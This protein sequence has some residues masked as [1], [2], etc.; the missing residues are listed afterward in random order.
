MFKKKCKSA[1]AVEG[2]VESLMLDDVC[3]AMIEINFQHIS[4]EVSQNYAI[5]QLTW[6]LYPGTKKKYV[7]LVKS[8]WFRNKVFIDSFFD[9]SRFSL[10]ARVVVNSDSLFQFCLDDFNFKNEWVNAFYNAFT[11]LGLGCCLA[12][13]NKHIKE[14]SRKVISPHVHIQARCT[15]DSCGVKF[16]FHCF[17]KPEPKRTVCQFGTIDQIKKNLGDL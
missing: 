8:F 5:N 6:K 13:K 16:I 1:G 4:K 11:K 12:F 7:N 14:G 2:H 15:F 10:S 9:V 3:M 17:E